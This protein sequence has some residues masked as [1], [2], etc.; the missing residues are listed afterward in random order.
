MSA[1]P[2]TP[3]LGPTQPPPQQVWGLLTG[4]KAAGASRWPP[5]PI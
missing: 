5:T 4:S 2:S 3:V 1:Y